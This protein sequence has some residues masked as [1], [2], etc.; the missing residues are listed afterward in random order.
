MIRRVAALVLVTVALLARTA[1]AQTV[2]EVSGTPPL[3]AALWLPDGAT[4]APLVLLLHG[5]G[6][7]WSELA[8]LGAALAGAGIAAAG[9]TQ[10]A[11]RS[12]PNAF[13]RMAA[14]ARTASR[15]LDAVLVRAGDRVDPGRLGVFG[16]SAGATAAMLLIGGRADP[17]RWRALCEVAPQERLCLSPFGQSALAAA[18][19]PA[20]TAPDSRF[21]AAMLAAPALGFLFAGD[22]MRGV[23]PGTAVRLWR[24]EADSLLAE[25]NHAEAIAPLLPG[26]PVPSVVPGADHWVFTPPCGPERRAAEPWLCADPPGFDR[27]AFHRAFRADAI[28]FFR[29]AL[30]PPAER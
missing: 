30:A 12:A 29:A 22:G 17:A 5:A 27:A 7:R 10:V 13:A 2:F 21:R 24:A 25:P 15:V 9:F 18:D 23:P 19:A 28:A 3:E 11:D 16:Y 26:H 20:F 6:G 4:R 1:V 14:R 8:P